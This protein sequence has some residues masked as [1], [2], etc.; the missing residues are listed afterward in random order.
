[1]NGPNSHSEQQIPQPKIENFPA[2]KTAG[3]QNFSVHFVTQQLRKK[4]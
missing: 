4:E 2:N 3:N 1:V